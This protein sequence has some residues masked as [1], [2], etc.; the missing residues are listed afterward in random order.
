M[1]EVTFGPDKGKSFALSRGGPIPIGR[2]DQNR[3]NLTDPQVSRSHC[4]IRIDGDR[5]ILTDTKSAT[6][7]YVN[8]ESVTQ[9]QLHAGD[10]IIIGQTRLDFR[11][12][13]DDEKATESVQPLLET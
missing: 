4:Q 5:V 10:A 2:G 8:G 11:W 9:R 7:T 1:L 6:G 12:S 13:D 3:I